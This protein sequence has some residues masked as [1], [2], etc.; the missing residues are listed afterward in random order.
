MSRFTMSIRFCELRNLF[1]FEVR[2]SQGEYSFGMRVTLA[3]ADAAA[4]A[5]VRSYKKGRRP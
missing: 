2:G 3:D 5:A 1:F 4:R